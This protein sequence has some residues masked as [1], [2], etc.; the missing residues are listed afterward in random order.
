[1]SCERIRPDLGPFLSGALEPERAAELEKHLE[2]CQACGTELAALLSLGEALERSRA[3]APPVTRERTRGGRWRRA[4]IGAAAAALL[5][6]GASRVL[7]DRAQSP[8]GELAWGA[9]GSLE[10]G[11]ALPRGQELV[12]GSAG[13]LVRLADGSAIAC[14]PAARL[15]LV[16][17]R[18]A[19]VAS[20]AAQFHVRP[21]SSPFG[22]ETARGRVRVL[23]TS[24][25]VVVEEREADVSKLG[26]AAA[27]GLVVTVAVTAG[28]VLFEPSGGGE[29]IR[30]A[31]GQ[32]VVAGATNEVRA[33]GSTGEAASQRATA[34]QGEVTRLTAER[35][36]AVGGQ[37]SL[38]AELAR[39][40]EELAALKQSASPG[41]P[42]EKTGGPAAPRLSWGRW[43]QEEALSRID[44]VASAEAARGIRERI[45][46]LLQKLQKGEQLTDEER[47]AFYK[48]NQK[49]VAVELEAHGKLPTNAPG[50]GAF[51]HPAVQANLIVEH[52]ELAGQPLTESQ[53]MQVLKA[54]QDYDQA[55]EQMQAGYGP[56]ALALE[57]VL[58]EIRL[59]RNLSGFLDQVL[60]PS[61][62][63]ALAAPGSRH[64]H[65]I[66]LYS[67]VLLLVPLAAPLPVTGTEQAATQL[68]Q[69]AVRWGLSA[70]Q[71]GA[72]LLTGWAV[73]A[74]GQQAPVAP[75]MGTLFDVDQALVAG[76]AQLQAMKALLARP[77]LPAE[78]RK[79]IAA[80]QGLAV[81]HLVRTQ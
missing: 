30:L 5:A 68:G 41:K 19:A 31:A 23:G 6:F 29:P 2:G 12:A 72:E 9:L 51:T 11:D 35:D 52:L 78:A 74:I 79:A 10:P 4:L 59:K 38:R 73:A 13:A 81:P 80:D 65:T 49:L 39:A 8:A 40:K 17:E 55:W 36:A 63:D 37:E 3:A 28:V 53:E 18:A 16:G 45:P 66:D 77:E 24:F 34:L 1:M 69:F 26:I 48:L 56:D 60:T 46:A 50:N 43:A 62:R 47:L 7:I 61:Q 57:K 20:G 75:G 32:Q 33:L 70:E 54:C 64:L 42:E 21:G 76:A 25:R 44:W 67:P 71:V 27:S 14:E 22:V 15:R 58:D